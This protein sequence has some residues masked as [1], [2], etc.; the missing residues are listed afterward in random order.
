M[1]MSRK[2]KKLK[3]RNFRDKRK[4]GK[5]NK[6][7][8]EKKLE[9]ERWKTSSSVS[10]FRIDK[11]GKSTRLINQ[12]GVVSPNET[13][14]FGCEIEK[15]VP[16]YIK[17][18]AEKLNLDTFI[19][20]P[21]R[22]KGLT[23][24]GDAFHCHYNA[25]ALTKRWGGQWLRGYSV[26]TYDKCETQNTMPQTK[27]IYHSVW[28]TPE[29]NAV[30]VSNNYDERVDIEKDF[31]NTLFIPF[32]LG[33]IEEFG[34][35][36]YNITFLNEWKNSMYHTCQITSDADKDYESNFPIAGLGSFLEK[37]KIGQGCLIKYE[38]SKECVEN[39]CEDAVRQGNFSQ[40]SLGSGKSWT[41]LRKDV[42]IDKYVD[43]WDYENKKYRELEVA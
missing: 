12:H 37:S 23:G 4:R 33:C 10:N 32:G 43:N 30:C 21:I 24:S 25:S 2:Q 9:R 6:R 20:V 26:F 3:K 22:T 36:I 19:R 14:M 40:K 16:P 41:E 35:S 31:D 7:E 38:P 5:V 34:I 1:K 29:G 18:F 39:F 27:F 42:G 11:I 28:I 13:K 17:D 8:I 15:S